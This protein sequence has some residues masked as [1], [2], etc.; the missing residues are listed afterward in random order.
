MWKQKV[1]K[2]NNTTAVLGFS[3]IGEQR[4]LKKSL[5]LYWKGEII[6]SDLE[7]TAKSLRERHWLYQ[8]DA[9]IDLIPC[10]DFSLYDNMLDLLIILGAEPTR[11]KDIDNT[12][13]RYFTMAK[14]DKTHTAME[15]TKWMNSNYHYIVPELSSTIEFGKINVD[16]IVTEYA[17]AKALGIKPKINI[18]GPLS[19]LLLSKSSDGEVLELF[20]KVIAQYEKLFT[21]LSSLDENIIIQCDEPSLVRGASPKTLSLLKIAYEKLCL[22]ASNAEIYVATYFEQSTEATSVLVHT[23]IKG[24]FLDFV[25][26]KENLQSLELIKKHEKILGV[27]LVDGRNIWINDIE[28]SLETLNEITKVISKDKIIV[29]TSSSLLHVPVSLKY[30]KTLDSELKSWMA[31]A[32]EKLSEVHLISSEFF[33]STTENDKKLLEENALANEKRRGSSLVHDALVQERVKALTKDSYIRSSKYKDRIKVQHAYLKLP[34]LPITTIGSFPQT[35][36]IRQTRRKYKNKLISDEQYDGIMKVLIKECVRFQE[37][38]DIDVLVHG[39]FERNDMVEYFGEQLKGFAFSQN[40]WVQSYGSRCVKPPVIYGD[41][42]R[43]KEMTVTWSAYAQSLTSKQMK[44]MLTGPVTILNWSFVRD[45]QERSLTSKQISM[46][47]SD[48]VNDLQNAGIN[49]IQVDEAAFKE[50]YP[51]RAEK[52]KTYEKWALESF[53]LSTAIAKDETQIHTHM[54]YSEFNDIIETIEDM[55]ADVI[56]IETARSGNEL[57]KV[58][59]EHGYKQEVGPGVYDIHSARVP[60][61]EEIVKQIDLLLEVLPA[62]QLWVNPDCGLKTRGWEETKPSLINMV[63]ATKE[64][65]KTL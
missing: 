1:Y 46:A 54:C 9:G 10:N 37:E 47:I 56:S 52:I 42:S 26:G 53:L 8:K 17:E 63:E 35:T 28:K 3:R 16:K 65:R 51:L 64:V 50:G 33:E 11:F 30:E 19:F 60:S 2:M 36:E 55:N 39:E 22:S 58:F 23:P 18:I 62:E 27:G 25:Y 21:K 29:S 6:L 61:K 13:E 4:E 43:P 12:L 15:M 59:K 7:D 45:D 38:I 57:L 48:E 14:G 20:D 41:V 34:S 24:L 31:Y 49:I 40:G 5:E 32:L 44:G